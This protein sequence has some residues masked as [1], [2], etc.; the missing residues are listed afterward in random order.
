MNTVNTY[1]THHSGRL[2]NCIIVNLCVSII[3]KNMDLSVDYK[4]ASEIEQ[5]GIPLFCGKNNYEKIKQINS[6]NFFDILKESEENSRYRKGEDL[7]EVGEVEK[8]VGKIEKYSLG[9]VTDFLQ[10]KQ[11]M[12]LL[13]D[14]LRTEDM[15][16]NIMNTNPYK[17]L[18]NN[19]NDCFIHIRLDDAAVYNPGAIY[20]LKALYSIKFDNLYLSTD[21]LDHPI[22]QNIQREYPECKV[23]SLSPIETLQFAS[24]HKNIILSHGS[25]SAIIGYLAF[26]S[27]I[28]YPVYEKDKMWHG[29]MFSISGWNVVNKFNMRISKNP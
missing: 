15:K 23:V 24:V 6:A 21:Q 28:Y 2:C 5:L 14:H 8:E 26:F 3:A 25:F 1:T 13:Y 27:D 22:I 20:Y 29:D 9:S 17:H 7:G 10:T 18:Y 19:N 11:I 16:R 4:Y 12:Q